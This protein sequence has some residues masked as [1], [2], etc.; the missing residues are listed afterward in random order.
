M[1][2]LAIYFSG[3]LKVSCSCVSWG[4]ATGSGRRRTNHPVAASSAT[5][6]ATLI[7]VI[8]RCLMRLRIMTESADCSCAGARTGCETGVE[9]A[10]AS[11][12]PEL[13]SRL[14]RFRSAVI[15]EAC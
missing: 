8:L 9:D 7:K 11:D 2:E 15:S 4:D 3:E 13:V 14:R 12:L 1:A 5:A 10:A 6:P